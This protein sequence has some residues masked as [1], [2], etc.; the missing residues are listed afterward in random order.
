MN[1]AWAVLLEHFKVEFGAVAFVAIK[2]VHRILLVESEHEPVAGDFGN[3]RSCHARK[4]GGVCPYDSFLRYGEIE[5]YISINNQRID[6]RVW[7]T[8]YAIA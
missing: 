7:F 8:F 4:Y 3:N 6:Y 1:G 5:Q 2:A